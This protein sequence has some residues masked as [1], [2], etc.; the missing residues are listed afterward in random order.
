MII[1]GVIKD[2][3]SVNKTVRLMTTGN[4]SIESINGHV[5]FYKRYSEQRVA[6]CNTQDFDVPYEHYKS[7]YID[8]LDNDL[9]KNQKFVEKINS[10]FNSA[11]KFI[12]AIRETT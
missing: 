1:D 9:G 7:H 6:L 4:V 8:P 12:E 5:T 2:M 10:A 3:T 11:L